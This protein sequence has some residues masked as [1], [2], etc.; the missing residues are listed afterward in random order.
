[1]MSETTNSLAVWAI[2]LVINL[3]LSTQWRSRRGRQ[4]GTRASGC[5]NTLSKRGFRQK[6]RP[7][8]A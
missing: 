5:I 1:M 7:K 2:L 6:F 4:V 3:N 8:Y